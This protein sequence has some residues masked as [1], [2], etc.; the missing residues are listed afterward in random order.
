MDGI[1]I[2]SL[3]VRGINSNPAKRN[4][5]FNH[6]ILQNTEIDFLQETH[7]TLEIEEKWRIEWESLGG[8]TLFF[9]HGDSNSKGVLIMFKK[10][11]SPNIKQILSSP[12]GRYCMLEI[13]I[14]NECFT[15]LNIYA[16]NCGN[17]KKEFYFD[18]A[19]LI[20][21]STNIIMAGDINL[22]YATK[23]R[24]QHA[25]LTHNMQGRD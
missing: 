15:L 12:N 7:S 20:T 6:C 16:P 2:F 8:G 23:D 3:N 10:S 14:F 4:K 22:A 1:G 11:F 13:E 21:N 5:I 18:I 17:D 19:K 9:S 24:S 25:T